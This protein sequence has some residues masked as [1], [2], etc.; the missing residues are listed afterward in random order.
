MKVH[1]VSVTYSETCSLPNYCNVKPT[2]SIT[3]EI[4]PDDDYD[5]VY[6][7]LMREARDAVQYE[8]DKALEA[9]DRPPKYWRGSRYYA[10]LSYERKTVAILPTTITTPLAYRNF[11]DVPFGMTRAY[12]IERVGR[13]MQTMG[14]YTL[15]DCTDGDLSKLEQI[16]ATD[17]AESEFGDESEF[18]VKEFHPTFDPDAEDDLGDDE[19][20]GD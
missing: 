20:V 8:V 19:N 7:S 9:A 2:I 4:G 6:E 17:E 14:G 3:A 18:G 10:A 13:L 5:T 15:I 16:A 1:Q 11:Y 12:A